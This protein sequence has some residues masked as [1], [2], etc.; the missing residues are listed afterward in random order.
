MTAVRLDGS[1]VAGTLLEV[2]DEA[3][4]LGGSDERGSLDLKRSELL[5]LEFPAGDAKPASQPIL[6]F[7]N[8]DRLYAEIGATDGD[9]LDVRRNEDALAVPIEA[10]RGITFQSLNPDD[11]TGAL[12]FRDEGADD[13]V[14]LTNGD[15]LAGQFVGLSESDLTIDTEGREVLVPRA[16]I[17]AIAFSPELTNAPTIDGPHQIVHDVS[18]WLTVQGL[19]QTDDGSWS[20]TTAFGAPASWARDGVRRVQ[21]LE[22]RVV[23]LSSLTP[24]NVE[25]TP[26]LDRVWPIRSNRA[27]T[28]EPLTAVGVTFA[29]GIGVHSRCRLSYDLG[30]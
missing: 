29:T 4:R 25:L 9:S 13:L 28:G 11:G 26:Y 7:A 12:L 22:G 24:A 8:G 6:E 2:T 27:V 1:S 18:G 15:R 17:S 3:L 16:R 23:P 14:L 21:F 10:M 30:G 20:G 5:S 19:K